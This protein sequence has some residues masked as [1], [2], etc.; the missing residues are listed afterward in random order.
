MCAVLQ[1]L[2]NAPQRWMFATLAAIATLTVG[3]HGWSEMTGSIATMTSFGDGL[4]F[5]TVKRQLRGLMS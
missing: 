3:V 2:G 5:Q 4:E 1:P